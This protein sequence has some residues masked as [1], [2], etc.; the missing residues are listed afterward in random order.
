MATV[1]VENTW[2]IH[3]TSGNGFTANIGHVVNEAVVIPS[4]TIEKTFYLA[5][6]S[7]ETYEIPRFP[8]DAEVDLDAA[9]LSNV[10]SIDWFINGVSV[11]GSQSLEI[12]DALKFTIVR[13][14]GGDASVT[15]TFTPSDDAVTI[16]VPTHYWA[17]WTNLTNVV[18][19]GSWEETANSL[20]SAG[21][22]SAINFDL[23][24]AHSNESVSGQFTVEIN[25][26][27][28]YSMVG[29]TLA[30]SGA[31]DSASLKYGLFNNGG[32]IFVREDGVTLAPFN[33]T[34]GRFSACALRIVDTG[35]AIQY[36]VKFEGGSF[37]LQYT[38]LAAYTASRTYYIAAILGVEGTRLEGV[39]IA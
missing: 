2:Q 31:I 26:L 14:A 24:G 1:T 23:R 25:R 27:P 17:S 3:R 32:D 12:G 11:S 15:L 19:D 5:S 35:A 6:N 7:S 21:G 37:T 18:L 9:T 8:F 39:K 36:W 29:L 4:A 13:T 33:I 30:N 38:S 10:A 34:G 28:P 22:G 20:R 16:D